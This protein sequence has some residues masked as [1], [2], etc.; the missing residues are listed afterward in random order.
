MKKIVSLITLLFIAILGMSITSE[1]S[2]SYPAEEGSIQATQDPNVNEAQ[3]YFKSEIYDVNSVIDLF[4]NLNLSN[5]ILD[6][7]L[8]CTGFEVVKDIIVTTDK[9]TFSVKY[10]VDEQKP[11]LNFTLNLTDNVHLSM[12]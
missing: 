1:A 7:D 12:S 3:I 10:N 6:Y 11:H 2:I 4:I 8:E 9:I 5:E